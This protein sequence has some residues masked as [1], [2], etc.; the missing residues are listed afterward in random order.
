[1]QG[2]A[3]REGLH[4]D[5]GPNRDGIPGVVAFTCVFRGCEGLWWSRSWASQVNGFVVRGVH[6]FG[7]ESAGLC[8]PLCFGREEHLGDR[9][10]F[11]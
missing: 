2:W 6:V 9:V 3:A 8:A 5:C 1:M 7:G 11:A 10:V 4:I